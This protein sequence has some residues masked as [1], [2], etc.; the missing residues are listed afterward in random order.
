MEEDILMGEQPLDNL[1]QRLMTENFMSGRQDDSNGEIDKVTPIISP[2]MVTSKGNTLNNSDSREK[3]DK[4]AR[5]SLEGKD[6][7]PSF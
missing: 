7:R 3:S 4:D 5:S 6:L 1:S 2:P